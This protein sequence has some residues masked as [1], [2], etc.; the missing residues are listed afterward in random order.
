MIDRKTKAVIDYAMRRSDYW[1]LAI[2]Y[3]DA[4]GIATDRKISP[5]RWR[6]AGVLMALCL[7]RAEPRQFDVSRITDVRLVRSS[8]VLI[9]EGV[10]CERVGGDGAAEGKADEQ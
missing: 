1:C 6:S 10:E 7:G 8:D 2:R 4:K 3:Q 5:I 9:G